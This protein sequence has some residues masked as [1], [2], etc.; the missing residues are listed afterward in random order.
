MDGGAEAIPGLRAVARPEQRWLGVFARR[1]EDLARDVD[2]TMAIRSRLGY[3]T[4]RVVGDRLYVFSR[5]GD[6]EA[7]RALDAGTGKTIWETPSPV[8]FTMNKGAARHRQGPKSPPA[9]APVDFRTASGR[10]GGGG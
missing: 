3:A 2:P 1:A 9:Y 4:P 6:N 10:S 8:S 7:M 5:R